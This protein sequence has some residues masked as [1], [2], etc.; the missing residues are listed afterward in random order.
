MNAFDVRIYAIRRRK[1]RRRPFEVR[2]HAAGRARSR[3][4][5]TRALAGGY[6]AELA[7]AARGGSQFGPVTGEPAGW[8]VPALCRVTWLEHAAGYAAVKWPHVSAH[9]R[10]G[11]ADALATITPALTKNAAGRPPPAVLRAAL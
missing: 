1:N 2:W 6:R 5:S 8:A 7:H 10:A 11:I 9:S 4:F 3:S